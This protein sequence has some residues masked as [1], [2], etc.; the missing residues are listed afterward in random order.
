MEKAADSV[1]DTAKE[2]ADKV[3]EATTKRHVTRIRHVL[4]GSN[5][6][7]QNNPPSRERRSLDSIFEPEDI[8]RRTPSVKQSC[9][10]IL[11]LASSNGLISS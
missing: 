7:Y 2:A 11:L 6:L 3:K 9:N 8:A 5:V 10:L 4:A 1:K